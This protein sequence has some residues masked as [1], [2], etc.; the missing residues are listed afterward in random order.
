M[1]NEFKRTNHGKKN[2]T[3]VMSTWLLIIPH[4]QINRNHYPVEG[5]RR[6]MMIRN[7]AF[8]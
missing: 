2:P 6:G 1:K 5:V 4:L 8:R 3:E 7:T